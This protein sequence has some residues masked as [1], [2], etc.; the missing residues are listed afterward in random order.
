MICIYYYGVMDIMGYMGGYGHFG[1]DSFNKKVRRNP[2]IKMVHVPSTI[3][4]YSCKWMPGRFQRPAK[5]I[6]AIT[7]TPQIHPMS[8]PTRL[9]L[10]DTQPKRNNPNIPP[11]KMLDNFHQASIMLSTLN[12]AIA[13]MI[14]STPTITLDIR[15]TAT[16]CLSVLPFVKGL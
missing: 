15:S 5:E 10:R 11:E 12:M 8:A 6:Q 9:I 1:V 3:A 7:R 2:T 4:R 13:T 16:W 14:P